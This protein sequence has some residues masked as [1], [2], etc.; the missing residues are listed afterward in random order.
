MCPETPEEDLVAWLERTEEALGYDDTIDAL[1][2]GLMKELGITTQAQLDAL[3]EA[4]KIEDIFA[5]HGI[6]PVTAHYPWGNEPRYGIQGMP[7]LWGWAAV[8]KIMEGEEW[9]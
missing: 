9:E 2:R 4:S 1:Q 8:Q 6:H 5:E 3:R 7:G